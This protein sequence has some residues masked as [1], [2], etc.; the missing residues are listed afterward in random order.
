M[1][2]DTNL[3]Q[4]EAQQRFWKAFQACA[5]ENRVR[6][7]LSPRYVKWVQSFTVFLPEKRL[8]DRSGKDILRL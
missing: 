5:E 3:A 1:N 8:Q 2:K 6:P 4:N 7:D